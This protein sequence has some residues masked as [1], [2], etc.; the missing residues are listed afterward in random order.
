MRSSQRQAY[1]FGTRKNLKS[2]W[3][4]FFMFCIYFEVDIEKLEE[5]QLCAF[6]Q[7]LSRSLKS[8]SS[9]LNYLS[10][11]KTLYSLM[12]KKLPFEGINVKLTM[13]GLKR[14]LAKPVDQ[15]RP[16]DPY[17]LTSIH[18]MLDM[19]CE[20]ELVVWCSLLFSF[21]LMLRSSQLFPKTSASR[22]ITNIIRHK[23]VK[24]VDGILLVRITWS[25]TIQFQQKCLILP[26]AVIPNSVLCPVTAYLE[27]LKV[28][29]TRS[30][31]PLFSLRGKHITY[32]QYTV[33][34][35]KLLCRAGYDGSQFTSHSLRRGG[36][37]WAFKKGVPENL[38]KT[39]GDWASEAFRSYLDVEVDQRLTVFKMMSDI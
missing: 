12:D 25:K 9:L 24:F 23:D 36:A 15:A 4:A 2:Q 37:T 32:A 13:K 11:V 21:F 7:F 22:Y 28:V 35:R 34:F 19:S 16:I 20:L 18:G 17:I 31:S 8:Y 33:I 10:A 29:D 6:L 14:V 1:A 26:L 3:T 30:S 27:M 38:I 39:Q 5:A